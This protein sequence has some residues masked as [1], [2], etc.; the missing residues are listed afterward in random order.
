[1]KINCMKFLKFQYGDNMEPVM[2][3][4]HVSHIDL[5]LLAKYLPEPLDF[6]YFRECGV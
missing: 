6:G 2:R 4:E 3:T 1:M 5:N